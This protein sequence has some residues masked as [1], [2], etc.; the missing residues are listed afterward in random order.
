MQF[1]RFLFSKIFLKQLLYLGLTFVGVFILISFGLKRITNHNEYQKVPAIMIDQNLRFEVID[2]TKF[3]PSLPPLSII[4]HL[5]AADSEVKKNRKIY[6]TVNPSGYREITVPNLIQITKRNAESI[7]KAVGF[8][9]G[10]INYRDNIGKDMV[11]EIQFKGK[12]IEP[13]ISLPKTTPIDLV[14][15]NGERE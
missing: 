4:A 1:L 11:L 7:L 15:G 2:S 5:P 3:V 6:L 10:E 13:G 14:L 8:E 9:L 12:K